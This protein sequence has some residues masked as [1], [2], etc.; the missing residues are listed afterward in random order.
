MRMPPR[1][2][3]MMWVDADTEDAEDERLAAELVLAAEQ[4]EEQQ[5]QQQQ[6]RLHPAGGGRWKTG[7]RPTA[8]Q[9]GCVGRSSLLLAST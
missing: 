7:K 4:R 3:A 2:Q 6:Q 5:Q 8:T 1:V 9:T